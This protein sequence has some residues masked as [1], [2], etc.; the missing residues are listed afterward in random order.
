MEERRTTIFEK[1]YRFY[2]KHAQ[3]VT[4]LISLLDKENKASIFKFNIDVLLVAPLVGFL[5][6][7]T[8]ERSNDK[9]ETGK[10]IDTSVFGDKVIESQQDFRFNY[11]LITLLDKEYEPDANKRIS[12]AFREDPS[13][14]DEERFNSFIRGGVEVLHEKIIGDDTSMEDIINNLSVFVQDFQERFGNADPVDLDV[15][16]D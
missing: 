11:W 1:Q 15:L 12:K 16:N 2:G 9:E 6:G 10:I 13:V 7:R 5:Y 14:E 8:A 3:F 4:D